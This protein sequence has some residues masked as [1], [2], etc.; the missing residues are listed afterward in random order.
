MRESGQILTGGDLPFYLPFQGLLMWNASQLITTQVAWNKSTLWTSAARGLKIYISTWEKGP[1][2]SQRWR[3]NGT[4]PQVGNGKRSCIIY[5]NKSNSLDSD[6]QLF[7]SFFFQRSKNYAKLRSNEQLHYTIT[8]KQQ[9]N[10]F[11]GPFLLHFCFS[12]LSLRKISIDLLWC[13]VVTHLTLFSVRLS[14][15]TC[16]LLSLFSNLNQNKCLHSELK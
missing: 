11:Q 9:Q 16:I 13:F 1:T 3:W 8:T 4:I 10:A 5:R 14:S 2:T 12:Q 15:H 6:S 7:F